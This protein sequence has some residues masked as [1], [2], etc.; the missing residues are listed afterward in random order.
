M[1]YMNGTEIHNIEDIEIGQE[2]VFLDADEDGT[3]GVGGEV[4]DIVSGPRP[5]LITFT[6]ESP[7]DG[8]VEVVVGHG[9]TARW[10]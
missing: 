9:D 7:H 3:F 4:I 2:V 5:G 10:V 1:I 8:E 6:V